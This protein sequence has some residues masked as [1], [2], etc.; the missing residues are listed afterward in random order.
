MTSGRTVIHNPATPENVKRRAYI[1]DSLEKSGLEW[2]EEIGENRITIT[3]HGRAK[4][5]TR[6]APWDRKPAL[7][8]PATLERRLRSQR[9][10]DPDEREYWDEMIRLA[11]QRGHHTVSRIAIRTGHGTDA[12]AETWAVM[13]SEHLAVNR[14]RECWTITHVET[15][16]AAGTASTFRD[17]LRIAQRVAEW[18]E[19]GSL[20]TPADVTPE[21]RLKARAAFGVAA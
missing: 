11:A 15:G 19:W 12:A 21:F 10:C 14:G 7:P 13:V 2:S 20:R 6:T 9:D 8:T 17:A 18:P 16:L 3:Y 5:R 4:Q 1:L